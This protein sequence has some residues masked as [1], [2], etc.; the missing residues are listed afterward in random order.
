MIIFSCAYFLGIIWHIIA[1][2]AIDWRNVNPI[3]VFQ[4]NTTF[5]TTPSYA[6]EIDDTPELKY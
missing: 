2:D 4:G 3:D 6:L 5:Y 1:K